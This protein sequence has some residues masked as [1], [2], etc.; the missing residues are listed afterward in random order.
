MTYLRNHLANILC[1]NSKKGLRRKRLG[2]VLR[3][4]SLVES[5]VNISISVLYRLSSCRE[6]GNNPPTITLRLGVHLPEII[7][8]GSAHVEAYPTVST[9]EL[10]P[11]SSVQDFGFKDN[12]AK[13]N[14]LQLLQLYSSGNLR[15]N[16]Q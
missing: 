4:F 2:I 7:D 3:T 1:R 16:F 11:V 15:K 13:L 14:G 12:F 9:V 5:N 6:E 10:A 8:N